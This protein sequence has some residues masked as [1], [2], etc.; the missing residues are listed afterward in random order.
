MSKLNIINLSNNDIEEISDF[1]K[2]DFEYCKNR[3]IN[4]EPKEMA[5][6]W[7]KANPMT[8]ADILRFYA[9]N[10]LYIFELT[11]ANASKERNELHG[12][13][14][15]FLLDYYLPSSHPRVLDYGAGVGTDTIKFAEKGYKTF[16]ADI[17]GK[18]SEFVKHRLKRRNIGSEYIAIKKNL[19]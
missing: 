12:K 6:E 7:Q 14:I 16:W 17:P 10:N 3:I 13:I 4:F 15:N 9:D 1:L 19:R 11:K 2:I 8:T 5:G 18:T